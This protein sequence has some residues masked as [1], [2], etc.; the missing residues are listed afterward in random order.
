M[1]HL[2][3]N[4]SNHLLYD[5]WLERILSLLFFIHASWSIL[6]TR[7]MIRGFISFFISIGIFFLSNFI[8]LILGL[9]SQTVELVKW[10]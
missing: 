5:G 4:L 3:V 6:R 1:E 9:F 10:I 8:D 2:I 7:L